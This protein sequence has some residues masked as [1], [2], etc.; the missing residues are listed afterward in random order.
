VPSVYAIGD[1]TNRVNL[2]PV[3]IRD[4]HAFADTVYNQ[5]PTPVDHRS[6]PSA[7]FGRPPIGTVGLGE[8]DARLSH[9]EIDIYR[10]NFRPMRNMLSGNQERTLMKLV[11]DRKSDKLLGVHI[12]GEDAPEM[13]QLAAVAVKA[14]LT[15]KQWDSTVALH[16]TAAEELV[17][18][19]ERVPGP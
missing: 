5:R 11:V 8:G 3:A 1:V 10:T 19:R 6:V 16:P 18:M 2:T 13:A 7:V 17:L 14:G 4:G 12:A 15:K 9:G